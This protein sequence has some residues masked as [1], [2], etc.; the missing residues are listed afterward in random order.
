[1]S[2]EGSRD[3]GNAVSSGGPPVQRKSHGAN[4]L[5]NNSSRDDGHRAVQG[6][7][8]SRLGPPLLLLCGGILLT[9]AHAGRYLGILAENLQG[10]LMVAGLVLV[11]APAVYA[12]S[13]S[14]GRRIIRGLALWGVACG[15]IHLALNIGDGI[16]LLNAYWLFNDGN[17]VHIVAQEVFSSAA[18]TL[19][20][21]ALYYYIVLCRTGEI[22]LTCERDRLN[23]EVNERKHAL[24]TLGETVERFRSIVET[25]SDWVWETDRNAVYTYASP[26]VRQLL[27]YDPE[28]VVG[29]TPFDFMPEEEAHRVA[30]AFRQF[31]E[32]Q[33]P[34]SLLENTNLHKKGHTVIVETSGVPVFGAGGRFRGYRGIDRDVTERKRA[35]ELRRLQSEAITQTLDGIAI[36]DVGGIIQFANPAWACMHGYSPE[37]VKGRPLSLFHTPEQM[38]REVT[39]FLQ[40]LQEKGYHSGEVG[41]A[42]RDGSIFQTRMS[43]SAVRDDCGV[44]VSMIGIARD[45]TK[46][47]RLEAQLRHTQKM[48]ALGAFAG[49]IAHNLRNNIASIMGWAEIASGNLTD[50]GMAR[51]CLERA[52]AAGQK[53]SDQIGRILTFSRLEESKQEPV[54]IAVAVEE[55]LRLLRGMLPSTIEL[56]QEIGPVHAVILADADQIHQVLINL[57]T[58]AF[59]AMKG[60]GGVLV[61]NLDEVEIG[62]EQINPYLGMTPGRYVRLRV[63]DTGHGMTQ[64]TID[65]I[66]DPFF[67]T[68]ERGLGTG[69]GL[70]VVHGIVENLDGAIDVSSVVGEGTSF[71]VLLPVSTAVEPGESEAKGASRHAAVR[72][73]VSVLL[74][75]DDESLLEMTRTGL[76]LL[77]FTVEGYRSGV[78]ALDAFRATPDRFDVVLTDEIMPGMTG[79]ELARAISQSCPDI[80]IV[81]VS[82]LTDLIGMQKAKD[83]GIHELLLKPSGPLVL[84]EAI[85]RVMPS[86]VREE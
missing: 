24:E 61:V 72:G 33:Q 54:R 59:D 71:T 6:P 62:C 38:E 14:L 28:E 25:T 40:T 67:T 55:G 50:E 58:N 26:K 45:I 57:G 23:A 22:A 63:N 7:R 12:L 8:R 80:P 82:G 56:R 78:E 47:R 27:G 11:F 81:M 36:T 37:E 69:L 49:G 44:V 18:F 2:T 4:A 51:A 19:L 84:A 32:S 64:A 41:H 75:D 48:D 31:L 1:L 5:S 46:E 42:R 79:I 35:D 76:E 53:A 30:T 60:T 10:A 43:T 83:A 73:R 77:G 20:A 13:R 70:S 21:G 29:K 74:I 39:P 3:D 86:I 65:H 68:K 66:F 85:R 15:L 9:F 52:I 17:P 34:F 16:P